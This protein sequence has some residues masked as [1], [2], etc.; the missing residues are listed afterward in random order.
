MTTTKNAVTKEIKNAIQ[1]DLMFKTN[2]PGL[3]H[4]NNNNNNDDDDDNNKRSM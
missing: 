4:L 2:G 1:T 3:V